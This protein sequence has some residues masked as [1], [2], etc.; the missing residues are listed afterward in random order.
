MLVMNPPEPS[1]VGDA[2]SYADPI[3]AGRAAIWF[4]RSVFTTEIGAP[5]DAGVL[6]DAGA[7]RISLAHLRALG[8][9]F[10]RIASSDRPL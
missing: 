8:W 5:G 9:N 6:D 4:H 1:V 3:R 2:P 7:L 10:S